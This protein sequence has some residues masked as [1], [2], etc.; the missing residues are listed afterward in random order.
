MLIALYTAKMVYRS[1]GEKGAG[2]EGFLTSPE[3]PPLNPL[4][5]IR[6]QEQPGLFLV[7]E[8]MRDH[9]SGHHF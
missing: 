5:L 8:L 7:V 9:P 3:P 1:V 6:P 4:P 2:G